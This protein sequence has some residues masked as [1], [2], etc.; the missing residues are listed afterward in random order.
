[1]SIFTS[2]KNRSLQSLANHFLKA[3]GCKI[4]HL[5]IGKENK[6][7][8]AAIALKGEVRPVLLTLSEVG[9]ISRN[10]TSFL[11]FRSIA[12]DREWISTTV[13]ALLK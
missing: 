10:K 1:M 8:V 5:S 12:L 11:S 6:T 7:I 2:V 9:I 4:T 13:N 3:Y